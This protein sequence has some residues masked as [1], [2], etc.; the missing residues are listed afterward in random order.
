MMREIV[1]QNSWTAPEIEDSASR[2]DAR[3]KLGIFGSSLKAGNGLVGF[4]VEARKLDPVDLLELGSVGRAE[5]CR[6]MKTCAFP[7]APKAHLV[8][9]KSPLGNSPEK[10]S[11]QIC[12]PGR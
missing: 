2:S 3:Q 12:L 6:K 10:C 9:E 4:R 7:H 8:K 11:E 1:H 5:G